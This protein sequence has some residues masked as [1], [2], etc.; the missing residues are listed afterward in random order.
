MSRVKPADV[1]TSANAPLKVISLVLASVAIL[2]LL[3]G[4]VLLAT[5]DESDSTNSGDKGVFLKKQ[6]SLNSGSM[7]YGLIWTKQIGV[8]AHIEPVLSDTCTVFE[9]KDRLVMKQ[10]TTVLPR[11][12][13]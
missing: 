11:P 9:P 5:T 13:T 6:E 10:R 12:M 8:D 2:A 7:E 1:V 4:L 3:I